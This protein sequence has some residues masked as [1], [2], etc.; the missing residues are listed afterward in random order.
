MIEK[1][2]FKSLHRPFHKALRSLKWV[3]M[4]VQYNDENKVNVKPSDFHYNFF[5]YLINR[6]NKEYKRNAILTIEGV[7]STATI[8]EVMDYFND[9]EGEEKYVILKQILKNRTSDIEKKIYS[10]YKATS[11][12]VNFAK[13]KLCFLDEKY[14]LTTSGQSLLSAK[15]S[16]FKISIKERNIIA[17]NLIENDTFVFLP[18]CLSIPMMKRYKIQQYFH[19]NFIENEYDINIF[20]YTKTSLE[21]NYTNVRLSWS[22]DLNIITESGKVSAWFLKLLTDNLEICDIAS[23]MNI[24]LENF[25]KTE[26]VAISKTQLKIDK[27][28]NV[29]DE[30]ISLKKDDIGYV[31]LYDIKKIMRM[32][33]DKFQ[34]FLV[35]FYTLKHTEY[36]MRFTNIVSNIDGRKRF[37]IKN[38]PTI[39]IKIVR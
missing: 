9:I 3:C 27:F 22:K 14:N 4:F 5:F 8:N 36:M 21:K 28:L 17:K 37:Y 33:Y 34:E 39:K 23:S 19:I 26:A 30:C 13:E 24:K 11:Y 29:Y 20:K 31:N 12:Y 7:P 38:T 1:R 25:F 32:S 18:L 6:L 10:T 35:L 16:F 15:S 2:F